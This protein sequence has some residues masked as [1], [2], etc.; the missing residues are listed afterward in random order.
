MNRGLEKSLGPGSS[1]ALTGR[2]LGCTTATALSRVVPKTNIPV[3]DEYYRNFDT[4]GQIDQIKFT[5]EFQRLRDKIEKYWH[6]KRTPSQ[7]C[8]KVRA[9]FAPL[10]DSAVEA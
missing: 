1:H 10:L 3:I 2:L 4:Q 7:E 5:T 9:N 6:V 8:E